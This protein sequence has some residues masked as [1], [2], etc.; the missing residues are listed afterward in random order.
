M[1]DGKSL[2]GF[3]E[4]SSVK[5]KIFTVTL[6]GGGPKSKL[7]MNALANEDIVKLCQKKGKKK[8]EK[9]KQSL[10]PLEIAQMSIYRNKEGKI[11]IPAKN[12][13]SCLRQASQQVFWGPKSNK[14]RV[15]RKS[16]G[17]TLLPSFLKIKE[18]FILLKTDDSGVTKEGWDIDFRRTKKKRGKP[19]KT[20][21]RPI[22]THWSMTFDIEISYIGPEVSDKMVSEIFMIA[23]RDIGLCAFR[24]ELTPRGA[25]FRYPFGRFFLT[26]I[27][28]NKKS[29]VA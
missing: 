17:Q 29:K 6:T 5:T 19:A 27:K 4:P 12:I 22:F 8:D 1:N 3:A 15:T 13:F 16:T 23:G 20:I 2:A 26:E 28:V 9:E 10:T 7:I 14:R 24:P 11:G 21:I 18:D 25:S